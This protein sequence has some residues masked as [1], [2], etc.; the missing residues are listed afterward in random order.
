VSIVSLEIR[1][2]PDS[3]KAWNVKFT[4]S[5]KSLSAAV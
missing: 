5:I 3:I 2:L 1:F 4:D